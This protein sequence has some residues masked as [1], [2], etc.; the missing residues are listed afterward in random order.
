MGFHCKHDESEAALCQVQWRHLGEDGHSLNRN[1]HALTLKG[2]IDLLR[3]KSDSKTYRIFVCTRS[4]ETL[5]I[6]LPCG[7]DWNVSI[8]RKEM[9]GIDAQVIDLSFVEITSHRQREVKIL[10]AFPLRS[11]HAGSWCLATQKFCDAILVANFQS[12]VA[13]MLPFETL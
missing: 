12:G 13:G 9:N 10:L 8:R 3:S 2:S 7:V 1:Y 6:P 4:G 11:S 5:D